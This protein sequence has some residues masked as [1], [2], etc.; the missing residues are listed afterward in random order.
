MLGF[1]REER[2]WDGTWL[3]F[4]FSIPEERRNVRPTLRK[5]LRWA[6]FA[7]LYDGLWVSPYAS[8]DQVAVIAAD[9]EIDSCVVIRGSTSDD[10]PRFLN[11]ISA[12][13]LGSVREHYSK[14]VNDFA[15]LR[16]RTRSGQVGPTE[17]LVER[18]K[19]VS[20]WRDFPE[21][22]PYL[23]TSLLRPTGRGT[24][25]ANCSSRSTTRSVTW[26]R[27]GSARSS[28]RSTPSLAPLAVHHASDFIPASLSS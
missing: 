8:S 25:R 28:E 26:L 13:D 6:G 18:T 22:D 11:P 19:I 21:L 12:W 2:D 10:L 20:A 9:L 5:K 15:G 24:R 27:S 7:P 23:P 16:E 14:F 17:A 4:A 3:F 1:G